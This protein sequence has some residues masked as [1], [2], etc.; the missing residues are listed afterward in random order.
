[1]VSPGGGSGG[2]YTLPGGAGEPTAE[3]F[4][5]EASL[6]ARSRSTTARLDLR[7]VSMALHLFDVQ[8]GHYPPADGALQALVDA[9]ELP[10]VARDPWG[11]A[12]LV[13]P[14]LIG[15]RIV[16]LGADG[17]PGGAGDDADLSVDV[18]P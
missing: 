9:G 3:A 15:L 13:Q 18:G 11:N 8:R 12:Y 16:S 4:S 7:N 1:M 10:R 17:A 2:S 6:G 5:L 14:R